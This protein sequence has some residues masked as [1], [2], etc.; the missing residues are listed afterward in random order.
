MDKPT[1]QEKLKG[2][3]ITPYLRLLQDAVKNPRVEDICALWADPSGMKVYLPGYEKT[4]E[5]PLSIELLG[6]VPLIT[7]AGPRLPWF[8]SVGETK[9][10]H[11]IILRLVYRDVS[12]LLG[13]DLNSP[14]ERHLLK[15][16]GPQQVF[17]SD[18]AKSCHHGSADFT[19]E[20]IAAVNASATVVSSG[21]DEPYSHP[22]PES[23]GALGRHSRGDRPLIFSTELA[24]STPERVKH[25]YELRL[26]LLN[27]R[28]E[29]QESEFIRGLIQNRTVAVYGMI[30]LRTD[31][32]Q[33]LLAQ[34]L[35]RPRSPSMKWDLHLLSR[36]S[37][38][39]L[40]YQP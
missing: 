5:R 27:A 10:G 6:P 15:Q 35:E 37:Q 38:G 36:N 2:T 22:Q 32:N 28:L 26:Q 13:G 12:I 24:R 9:N 39:D 30:T 4:A 8:G 1:L 3:V 33:A 29:D 31:G 19:D 34:K 18:I 7:P 20:F 23:L 14:A 40:V 16:Y 21:D 17:R 11:S 25:P